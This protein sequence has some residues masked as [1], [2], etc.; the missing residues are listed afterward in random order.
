MEDH[1]LYWINCIYLNRK[2]LSF[3]ILLVAGV[4]ALLSRCM[5]PEAGP[6]TD[7]RGPGYAG[8]AACLDCHKGRGSTYR[9]TA[10]A[11]TSRVAD[12]HTVAGP[13]GRGVAAGGAGAAAGADNEFIYDADHK[14]IMEER[15]SGLFQVAVTARGR[16]AHR[17]D[18][19]VGSG[20]KAQTYLYWSGDGVFQLPV[21]YFLTEHSWANSPYYPPD[22]IWFD[23]AVGVGCFECH[24]SYIG[25][26]AML[27]KNF[28]E[29]TPQYDRATLVYGVD[30]ER[31][32]GP[33]ALHVAWQQAH[34]ED[35]A[36]RYMARFAGLTRQQRLDVCAVCHSG[37]HSGQQ[38]SVF[39]FKPGDTLAN[40]YFADPRMSKAPENTD[41]HGNQ[42]ELLAAS[43]CYLRSKTLECG[44]CH[45][46]HVRERENLTVFAARC[47][48]CHLPG[49]QVAG[50][51][52]RDG[53]A[54][55][56]GDRV[57]GVEVD[58]SFLINNCIDCHMPA[59]ASARI[60]ML[61]Q[62]QRDPIADLVRS[63][64]ITVYPE[65]TKRK[66]AEE[67]KKRLAARTSH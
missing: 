17:F 29:G 4:V 34:P 27:H 6:H 24:S 43:Q 65:E 55:H 28:F 40:Y 7:P 19:A 56:A 10:H 59:R 38:R 49:G 16:E 22:S 23:R 45:D 9:G 14:V 11:L 12:I 52:A 61:T 35:T 33:G 31:C 48:N 15:D 18:I 63:H 41:V 58:R 57:A 54:A 36:A 25:T 32:H 8:M 67:T 30:C 50:R 66:L 64:Y 37:A 51:P 62:T 21:S 5:S 46:V 44:S 3:V 26:K 39:H 20:R 53:A 42:Y 60:T 1:Y 13:F 2:R 47:M